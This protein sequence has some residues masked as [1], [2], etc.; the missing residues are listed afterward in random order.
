M[1]KTVAILGMGWLGQKL[2]VHLNNLNYHVKGSVMTLEKATQLQQRGFDAYRIVVS[3]SGVEGRTPAL[4]KAVDYAIIMIPPGLRRDTGANFFMKMQHL[5]NEIEKHEIPK[6]ILISS[7]AVYDDAQ[8]RVTEADIPRPTTTTAKQMLESEELFMNSS[9]F[10]T[11]IIRFGGIFGGS[12]QPLRYLT[13]RKNLRGGRAPVNLIHR[14]DCIGIIT[15]VLEKEAMGHIFNAVH[16]SHPGKAAY[17]IERAKRV[18]LE[19]PSFSNEFLLETYKQVD[20]V[21][22][23]EILGYTFIKSI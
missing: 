21:N 11:T 2:A 16:P 22:L 10:Q 14:Q 19:P 6:V 8:G 15:A 1:N 12:R 20:S 18:G 9:S 17:Y 5:Y 3:D 13:G 23:T 7:I 4:L